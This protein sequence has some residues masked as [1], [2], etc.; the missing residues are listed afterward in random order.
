[1][2]EMRE[3]VVQSNT[4]QRTLKVRN[5]DD[6]KVTNEDL[7]K[8]F[9][10]IGKLKAC[11]FDRNEFGVFTGSATVTY[12]KPESAREAI[13][14]YNGAYLDEKLLTVE[15]ASKPRVTSIRQGSKAIQKTGASKP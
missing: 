12:E 13:K 1:M 5:I 7:K 8:L 15:L 9:E 2:K 10:K 11:R 6:K 14:N 4:A 3:N